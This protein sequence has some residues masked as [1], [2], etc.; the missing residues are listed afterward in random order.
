M[1]D[2][3]LT[4]TLTVVEVQALALAT[5]WRERCSVLGRSTWLPLKKA[6]RRS[7]AGQWSI[8]RCGP[9]GA[10]PAQAGMAMLIAQQD[11]HSPPARMSP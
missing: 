4:F 11:H 3:T 5:A 1:S 10:A 9:C 7:F 8:S 2:I 6:M